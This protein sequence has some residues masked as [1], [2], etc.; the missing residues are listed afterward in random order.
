MF[1]TSPTS[2]ITPSGSS[3]SSG[4][5]DG[6]MMIVRAAGRP[7]RTVRPA[8]TLSGSAPPRNA[9]E[10]RQILRQGRTY[11]PPGTS[12]DNDR[13]STTSTDSNP[14]GR[15]LL[16]VENQRRGIKLEGSFWQ[17]DEENRPR[18]GGRYT[19]GAT[20]RFTDRELQEPLPQR[21][22]P[23]PPPERR[24]PPLVPPPPPP[25][26]NRPPPLIQLE[27]PPALQYRPKKHFFDLVN[28][29]E[30]E[31]LEVVGL[32]TEDGERI[33]PNSCSSSGSSTP[34][35][36]PTPTP[37][38]DPFGA[39]TRITL[40]QNDLPVT[41]IPQTSM[42]LERPNLIAKP[43]RYF[44][45]LQTERLAI[46]YYP[47]ED[48]ENDWTDEESWHC[49]DGEW[50][51]PYEYGSDEEED[52]G[53]IGLFRRPYEEMLVAGKGFN[54]NWVEEVDDWPVPEEIK[55]FGYR[56]IGRLGEEYED[57]DE[58]EEIGVR[59]NKN[60]DYELLGKNR[61]LHGLNPV[62]DDDDDEWEDECDVF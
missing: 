49:S 43:V 2:S 42:E 39:E 8:S 21:R 41:I 50:P 38:H 10:N 15:S 5:T 23:S 58:K 60:E 48:D 29:R 35:R 45:P 13:A 53:C 1:Y 22:Q 30:L 7:R 6:Q 20:S 16:D 26:D 51:D 36:K 33:Y 17:P 46:E 12:N 54:L 27:L 25:Q 24:Q 56:V 9:N 31:G 47:L 37:G 61:W 44:E 32:R 40:R 19:R 14:T 3:S 18:G 62:D 57:E 28:E 55:I 59:F 11:V 34:E 52:F 4:G